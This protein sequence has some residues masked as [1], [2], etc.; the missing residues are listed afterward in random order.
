MGRPSA[1]GDG[2]RRVLG[3]GAPVARAHGGDPY[4]GGPAYAV[5]RSAVRAGNVSFRL[6]G[7]CRDGEP[8]AAVQAVM[9]RP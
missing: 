5:G 6:R 3:C 2:V 7:E 9:T 8:T 4:P 1:A